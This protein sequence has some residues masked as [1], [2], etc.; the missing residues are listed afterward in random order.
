MALSNLHTWSLVKLFNLDCY[1]YVMVYLLFLFYYVIFDYIFWH[2][3]IVRLTTKFAIITF[4]N[5]III[6][7]QRQKIEFMEIPK[8]IITWFCAQCMALYANFTSQITNEIEWQG[9]KFSLNNLNKNE[10]FDGKSST[11]YF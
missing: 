10:E 8:F 9:H 11:M 7:S 5:S 3:V 2:F 1:S 6:I 4:F